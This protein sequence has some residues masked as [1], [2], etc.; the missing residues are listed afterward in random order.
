[1]AHTPVRFRPFASLILFCVLVGSMAAQNILFT[2]YNGKFLAVMRAR[3]N[4]PYVEVE[5]KQVVAD[6]HS[7]ILQPTSEYLP[8]FVGLRNVEVKTSHL[9]M[10][11]SELNHEFH[12]R[13]WLTS[14]YN[15]DNVFIVLELLTESAGKVL[16]LQEVGQ[17]EAREDKLIE[18][19]VRL[20]SPLGE[21]KYKLHIFSGG[22]EVLHSKI[23]P[24]VRDAALDRMT[25]KRIAGVQDAL[26]QPFIGPSPEYPEAL[27][28]AKT[29]GRAIIAMRIGANGRV[30][31]PTIKS[32]TDPAFG[33]TALAAARLFRFLPRMV[34]G[35]PVE[36]K[37]E[38]PIDFT[39]PEKKGKK[40]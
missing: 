9:N 12:F 7:Y 16:F 33:E 39:P 28:K 25:L 14:P 1:M 36:A 3:F 32:A 18:A 17:L 23:P 38:L 5:G 27:L 19:D 11:G 34:K 30:Y 15:L 13:A 31:D 20:N 8:L 37:V 26:P 24:E 10:E 6:G 29:K 22:M 35:R 2:D 21:G 4:T 40:S